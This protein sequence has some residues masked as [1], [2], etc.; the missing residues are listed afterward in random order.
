MNKSFSETFLFYSPLFV[1]YALLVLHETSSLI[2]L[3][4]PFMLMWKNTMSN[5]LNEDNESENASTEKFA[6]LESLQEKKK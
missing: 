5:K 4:Q 3:L 1:L 2:L 6:W